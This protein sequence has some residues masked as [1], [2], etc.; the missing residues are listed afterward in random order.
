MENLKNIEEFLNE[1]VNTGAAYGL[2]KSLLGIGDKEA[3]L[4]ESPIGGTIS[5]IP[6][7]GDKGKNIQAIMDAMKR[8]NITNPYTQRAILGCIGKESGFI[9][10]NELSYGNTSN[11]R[12]RKIFGRR[13][14]VSDSELERIKKDDVQFYDM[15]YGAPATKA[16]GFNTGNTAPGDGHKYRGRGFNGITFKS[17]YQRYQDILKTQG[18]LPA[19]KNVDIVNNPDQLNDVDIAA[20]AAILFFI[21]G[22]NNSTMQSKYGTKDINA[23]KDQDTALKGIVNINAGLGN[24]IGGTYL[25]GL[26]KATAIANQFKIDAPTNNIA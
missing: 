22:A 16:L 11:D 21:N 13:I 10:Q 3:E 25:A 6:I 24:N 4:G 7:S 5:Q 14:T 15:V 23:F 18:K 26:E 9:P 20:E 2:F 17:G 1:Q 19:G 8:H 12:I